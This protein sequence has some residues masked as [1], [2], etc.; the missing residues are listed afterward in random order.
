M[1]EKA[2]NILNGEL[3]KEHSSMVPAIPIINYLISKCE[4]DEEFAERIVLENKR[5]KECFEYVLQEVRKKLNNKNGWIDDPEVY[6]MAETYYLSDD[7]NLIEKPEPR[8]IDIPKTN[9]NN[10][11][12]VKKEPKKDQLSLFDM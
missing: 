7:E 3:E 5:I 6:A 12:V 1:L 10:K 2:I 11:T 8:V 9:A 4:N